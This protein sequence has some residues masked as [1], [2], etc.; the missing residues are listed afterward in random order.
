M[1]RCHITLYLKTHLHPKLMSPLACTFLT[2]KQYTAIQNLYIS[3]ALSA[4]G[5][6][7]TWSV[8]LRYGDHKYCGLQLRK[9][10]SETIIQKIQ[11][12]QLLVMKPDTSKLIFTMLAWYQHVLGLG[13][14]ILEQ[15]PYSVN[16]INSCWLNDFVRL[17]RK[18]DVE[19]KLRTTYLQ[20][21]LRENDSFLMDRILTNHFS[22]TAIKKLHACR[23]YLQVTLLS[24]IANLKGD[25]LL[26]NSLHG[27]R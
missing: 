19:I 22:P 18:Y 3:L 4:M 12:L 24:G 2:S 6:N 17:L 23:L 15:H 27:M 25:R 14:P 26:M 7:H 5:Y 21:L 8:A 9:L 16:Y 10:E 11:Q 13:S 1:N 20:P